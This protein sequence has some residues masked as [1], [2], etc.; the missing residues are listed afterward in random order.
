M[1]ILIC[2]NIVIAPNFTLNRHEGAHEFMLKLLDKLED[3]YVG[4]I[5]SGEGPGLEET[6]IRTGPIGQIFGGCLKSDGN[7]SEANYV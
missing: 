4:G 1:Q 3:S 6:V 5:D 7:L 2:L